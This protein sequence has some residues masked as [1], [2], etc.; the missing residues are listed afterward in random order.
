[1]QERE[2]NHALATITGNWWVPC[3]LC[4]QFFGDH[5]WRRGPNGEPCAI[6]RNASDPTLGEA[7][8]PDCTDTKKGENPKW[9]D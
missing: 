4:R 1:M 9:T 6:Y 5:E 7:I 8:C 2:Y 3:P